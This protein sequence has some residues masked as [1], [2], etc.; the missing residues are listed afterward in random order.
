MDNP[1]SLEMSS[2]TQTRRGRLERII[3]A[4]GELNLVSKFAILCVFFAWFF[5]DTLEVSIGSL[6]HGVRFFDASAV[7][8]DPTRMFFSIDTSFGVVLF[9]LVCCLCLMGPLLPHLWRHRVAWLGYLLPLALIVVCGLLL[10]TKTSGD[11]LTTPVDASGLRV[12]VMN[13]A[14]KILQ[15]GSDLIARHISVGAGGYV[16][17]LGS[18]VLGF[19][20]LRRFSN[21]P[22]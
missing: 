8:A 16:A 20:G 15:R 5:I 12:G 17:L 1:G 14:N 2:H 19:Q 22:A 3:T 13:L 7:I 10:Y 9:A 4:A 18:L 21:K 11:L 6:K